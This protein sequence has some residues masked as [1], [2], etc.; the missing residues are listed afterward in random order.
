MICI[1]NESLFASRLKNLSA[2]V[3]KR[4]SSTSV[5]NE[6]CMDFSSCKTVV[7]F[8]T[9]LQA[10]KNNRITTMQKKIFGMLKYR[11]KCEKCEK[12]ENV[13]M[14]EC[15]FENLKWWVFK[16]RVIICERYS[17]LCAGYGPG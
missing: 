2:F 16:S 6:G 11:R 17:G 1:R 4:L 5:Y 14:W 3:F 7:V 15:E 13:R 10:E 8:L 12:C 9:V